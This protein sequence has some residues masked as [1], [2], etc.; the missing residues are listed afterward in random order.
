MILFPDS[1]RW[2]LMK[3]RDEDALATLGKLRRQPTDDPTLVAEY[4][5][6]KASVIVE[7][8]FAAQKYAGMSGAKL[9][10]AQVSKFP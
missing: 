2:L 6:I 10:A 3:D 5:E 7:N 1:P 9:H 4:L 8:T